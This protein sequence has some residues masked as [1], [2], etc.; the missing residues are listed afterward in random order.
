MNPCSYA[1]L[2]FDRCPQVY[3][4][5]KTFFNKCC[6]ENWIYACMKLNLDPCLSSCTSINSKWIEDLNIKPETLKLMQ[7]IVGITLQLI[8]IGNN[9]LN[10]TPV[11]QQLRKGLT[12]GTT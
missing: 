8:G 10:S 6:W 1:H 5:E 3:D 11:A 4:G 9:F 7:K 2:I 12:N